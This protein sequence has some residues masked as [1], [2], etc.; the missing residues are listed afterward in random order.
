MPE[1]QANGIQPAV[2]RPF[3]WFCPRCR[4]K[5]VRPATISYDTERL[6]EGRLIAVNIPDL[7]VPKCSN[8][9]EL[10]FNYTADEQILDAVKTQAAAPQPTS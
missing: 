9:G 5:E 8:C 3:P 2:G 10:V 6:H 1:P 4:K 7:A